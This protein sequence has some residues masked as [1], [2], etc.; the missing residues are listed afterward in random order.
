MSCNVKMV[1]CHITIS[2]LDW[3]SALGLVQQCGRQ[4]LEFADGGE[5]SSSVGLE[6]AVLLAQ[7]KLHG[8]EVALEQGR[9]HPSQTEREQQ[10]KVI[11]VS[12]DK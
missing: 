1:S 7:T 8:E 2:K 9:E 10:F 11:S 12:T 5:E 3:Y 4:N 6:P